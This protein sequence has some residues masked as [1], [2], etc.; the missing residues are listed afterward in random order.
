[1]FSSGIYASWQK[2]Q[3]EKFRQAKKHLG[4]LMDDI[5]ENKIVLDVGCGSGYLE[6]KFKGNFIGI[7][8]ELS[9]LKN[10]VAMFQK[11]LA[12]AKDLPFLEES[13]DTVVSIDTMHTVEGT[14]FQRVLKEGGIALLSI[15]F[16]DEN[17]PERKEMLLKKIG[18]MKILHEFELTGREK[19][20]VVIARK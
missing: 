12:D 6:G 5:F 18:S 16:N 19:E 7:D 14:D 3:K 2:V 13:F 20:Y 17:Y 1:M 4:P 10:S 9:M 15:F 8:R 11:V